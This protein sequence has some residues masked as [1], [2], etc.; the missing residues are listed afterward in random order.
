MA[1]RNTTRACDVVLVA[2]PESSGT[3]VFSAALARHS[4]ITGPQD[5]D[6]HADRLDP[7]WQALAARDASAA[8]ARMPRPRGRVILTRR[9][10]PHGAAPGTSARYRTYPKLDAF[11]DVCRDAQLRLALLVTLRDPTANLVSW[12]KSRASAAGRMEKAYVQYH[13]SLTRLMRFAGRRQ[14][15]FLI[16]PLEAYLLDG[17][18]FLASIFAWLGLPQEELPPMPR[19][20]AVNRK[21]REAFLSSGFTCANA[22]TVIRKAARK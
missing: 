1:K 10:M 14:L 19:K 21:H 12:H 5:A 16:C 2:G 8:A 22:A 7:V 4:R 6:G 11:A 9:S 20:R 13:E 17:D 3:R 15:P 18:A